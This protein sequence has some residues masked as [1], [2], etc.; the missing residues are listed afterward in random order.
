VMKCDLLKLQQNYET[1]F[2]HSNLDQLQEIAMRMGRLIRNL[3]NITA[4]EQGKNLLRMQRLNLSQMAQE[5]VNRFRGRAA[6]KKIQLLFQNT[7]EPCEILADPDAVAQV[8]DNL[9]SNAIKYSPTGQPVQVK[10]SVQGTK[11]RFTVRDEGPGIRE[12]EMSSLFGAFNKLS[13]RPTGNEPSHGLGLAI[14]KALCEAMQAKV[15]CESEAGQGS[16]FVLEM[17]LAPAESEAK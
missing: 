2:I 3:L 6:Q 9:I 15:W 1:K 8:L 17:A 4:I 7:I 16:S 5:S 13:A 11:V 12:D 14:V 10:V